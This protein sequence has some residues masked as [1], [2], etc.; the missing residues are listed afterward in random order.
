[1]RHL[2]D[3]HSAAPITCAKRIWVQ[4]ASV[5]QLT[6]ITINPGS[7]QE[8]LKCRGSTYIIGEG[9][10]ERLGRGAA[11]SFRCCITR[12]G[13]MLVVGLQSKKFDDSVIG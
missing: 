10:V 1:M 6:I 8:R 4:Y 5:L 3:L 11:R 7:G 12:L 13:L 9:N 2:D